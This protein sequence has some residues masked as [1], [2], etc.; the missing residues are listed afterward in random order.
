[1]KSGILLYLI[2]NSYPFLSL[3]FPSPFIPFP[4]HP[5]TSLLFL[6][7]PFAVRQQSGVVI[8]FSY[9]PCRERSGL[10]GVGVRVLHEGGVRLSS[11]VLPLVVVEECAAGSVSCAKVW[12][13]VGINDSSRW[14]RRRRRLACRV[15]GEQGR[16]GHERIVLR[17]DFSVSFLFTRSFPSLL[18]L[19]VCLN[20]GVV[21]MS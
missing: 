16:E 20:V 12:T 13:R 10:V 9:H 6:A 4:S 21:V 2:F 15:G 3:P 19:C 11:L 18:V 14:G 8:S 7:L 1:M 17:R 5:S